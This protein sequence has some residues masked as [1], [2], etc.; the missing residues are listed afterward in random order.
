MGNF[1]GLEKGIKS[2]GI[3]IF[4]IFLLFSCVGQKKIKNQEL[5]RIQGFTMG[6]SYSIIAETDIEIDKIRIDS[7]LEEFNQ[8]FST[9]IPLSLVSRFN[10]RKQDTFLLSDFSQI[11]KELFLTTLRLCDSVYDQTDGYFD[12]TV[13]PLVNYWGFGPEKRNFEEDPKRETIDSL[14][15]LVGFSKIIWTDEYI[16][17]PNGVQLDFSAV[18]KGYGVDVLGNFLQEK[19]NCHN[20]LVEIGGE[21][22]A[23]GPG[24]KGKGW[25]VGITKPMDHVRTDEIVM[26]LGLTDQSIAT[27][28]NYQNFYEIDGERYVHILNPKSGYSEKS[29]LLSAS[30]LAHDCSTA[31]AWATAFM[32][33]GVEKAIQKDKS[34]DQ[35]AGLFIY[36]N[37]KGEFEFYISPE[38]EKMITY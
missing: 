11:Q 3:L 34:T 4:L 8:I 18:A 6:T 9:Y 22:S 2:I 21:T 30:V 28:G 32:S 12:P 20:Y 23:F 37:E 14:L 38:F 7:L 19:Y 29:N 16:Y 26:K 35:V 5:T 25:N 27:S 31:D 33:M 24:R 36:G 13:F 17:A 1:Y 10:A 15:D